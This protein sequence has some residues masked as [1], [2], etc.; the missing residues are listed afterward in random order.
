MRIHSKKRINWKK[1]LKK[2]RNR[3]LSEAIQM[4]TLEMRGVPDQWRRGY[5][6]AITQLEVMKDE[7]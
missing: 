7:N 2:E 1:E 4:I 6:S 5:Y 3:V